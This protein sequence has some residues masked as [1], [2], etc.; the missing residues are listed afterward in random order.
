M[1]PRWLDLIAL[2]AEKTK[3][4]KLKPAFSL[5]LIRSSATEDEMSRVEKQLANEP[6]AALAYAYHN[7]YNYSIDPERTQSALRPE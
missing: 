5:M 3:T 7:I 1:P 2:L 4:R 6:E